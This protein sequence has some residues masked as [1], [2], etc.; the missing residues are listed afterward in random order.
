MVSFGKQSNF[1]IWISGAALLLLLLISAGMFWVL[2]SQGLAASWSQEMWREIGS[3]AFG[4]IAIVVVMTVFVT[5]LGI[6]VAIYLHEYATDGF[7]VRGVRVA[8]NNLA[9]VP[10]IVG[11]LFGLAFFINFLGEGIDETFFNHQLPLST[12]GKGGILWASLTL[13]L[14]TLPTMVIATENALAAVPNASREEALALAATKLQILWHIVRPNA[15]IG[16]CSGITLTMSRGTAT[17][18]PL[19]I[20]STIQATP[21][22]DASAFLHLE[23]EFTHLG[24]HIFDAG[25]AGANVEA[26]QSV[27]YTAVLLLV[28]LTLGFHLLAIV[29]R[30][31]P[32]TLTVVKL[33]NR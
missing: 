2:L 20:M 7:F 22:E 27:A 17:V 16:I 4:T 25:V 10:A 26:A 31:R 8:L 6:L 28:L 9:G 5:P 29:L 19:I 12:F 1:S 11:G 3:A 23:R 21:V 15:I 13:A 24:F 30:N 33:F 18:A 32:N 14:L